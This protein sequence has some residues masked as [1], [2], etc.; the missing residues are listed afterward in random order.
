M[1]PASALVLP[2]LSSTLPST[3]IGLALV[4]IL[5]PLVEM[6]VEDTEK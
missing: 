5:L 2:T 4:V 6:E 3:V 1:D